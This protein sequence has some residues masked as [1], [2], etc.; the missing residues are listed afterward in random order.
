LIALAVAVTLR[1]DGCITVHTEAAIK[2]GATK[3]EMAEALGVAT[4]V[5]AG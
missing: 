5:N 3:N 1:C 2:N 4:A